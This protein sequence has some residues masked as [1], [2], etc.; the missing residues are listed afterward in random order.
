MESWNHKLWWSGKL[1]YHFTQWYEYSNATCCCCQFVYTFEDTGSRA[2]LNAMTSLHLPRNTIQQLGGQWLIICELYILSFRYHWIAELGPVV[3]LIHPC[4]Y[5]TMISHLLFYVFNQSTPISHLCILIPRIRI[6][7]ISQLC[8]K[9]YLSRYFTVSQYHYVMWFMS[10]PFAFYLSSPCHSLSFMCYPSSVN[11]FVSAI[12]CF[13]AIP[14]PACWFKC[15]SVI[16]CI[17]FHF[18]FFHFHHPS[19]SYS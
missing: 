16:H 17:L 18:T 5:I 19:S 14:I 11:S 10:P 4:S 1:S 15:I 2:S 6:L 8:I 9:V 13:V 7:F 3:Y 12:T